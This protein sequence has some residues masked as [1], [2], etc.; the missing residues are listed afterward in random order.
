[1]AVSIA[2]MLAMPAQAA[3]SFNIGADSASTADDSTGG[4]SGTLSLNGSRLLSIR[5]DQNSTSTSATD[6][7][8]SDYLAAR[9]GKLGKA[10]LYA[11]TFGPLIQDVIADIKS[12]DGVPSLLDSLKTDLS[13]F[14]TKLTQT[15]SGDTASSSILLKLLQDVVSTW[16][17]VNVEPATVADAISQLEK[18][19]ILRANR[20]ADLASAINQTQTDDMTTA[21]ISST[22]DASPM[23]MAALTP[24]PGSLALLLAGGLVMLRRRTH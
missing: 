7:S 4:L 13:D 8:L 5:M 11:N 16:P 1:V 21:A 24:E 3:I 12:S 22:A 6:T 23:L 15:T 18:D 2:A 17:N 19:G 14:I 9:G 10:Y 20:A